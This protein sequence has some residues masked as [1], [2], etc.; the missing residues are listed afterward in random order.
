VHCTATTGSSLIIPKNEK[1][2]DKTRNP[3]SVKSMLLTH[4]RRRRRRRRKREEEEKEE[5]EV[6]ENEEEEEENK[7]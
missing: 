2:P 1:T 7:D 6:K 4:T 5:E 3:S